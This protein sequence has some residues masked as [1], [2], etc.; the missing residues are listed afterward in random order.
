MQAIQVNI[1]N[2]EK[3]LYISTQTAVI[4]RDIDLPGCCGLC[5]FGRPCM[6]SLNDTDFSNDT[7][8]SEKEAVCF[9]FKF[10]LSC[11]FV[12]FIYLFYDLFI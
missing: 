4:L 3:K 5:D 12:F 11:S 10:Y 1:C 8:L 9:I 2:M 6:S 7:D